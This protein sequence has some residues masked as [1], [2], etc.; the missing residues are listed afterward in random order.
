[1]DKRKGFNSHTEKQQQVVHRRPNRA[2]RSG[3]NGIWRKGITRLPHIILLFSFYCFNYMYTL[4]IFPAKLHTSPSLILLVP[5]A[6]VHTCPTYLVSN[7]SNDILPFK[8]D[9]FCRSVGRCVRTSKAAANT[10]FHF[11]FSELL[12]G[13]KLINFRVRLIISCAPNRDI[14]ISQII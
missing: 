12:C 13:I 7:A 14:K 5:T 9:N 6:Y 3:E 2:E 10:N 1:M 8:D 11:E 4:R